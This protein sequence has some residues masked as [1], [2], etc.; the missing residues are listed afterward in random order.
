MD[1][2]LNQTAFVSVIIP[3]FNRA[4]VLQTA[5]DSVLAQR[6]DDYELIVVD[7]GSTDSTPDLL[8]AYGKKITYVRQENRGVSAARNTGIRL[9]RGALITFL[10]SDDHW[11][12]EKLSTQVAFFNTCPDAQIC[13][14]EEIWIRNGIRVNP[15]KKHAKPSGDI[16]QR[17]LSLCLV[18]PSAV[19]LRRELFDDVGLFDETLPACE[20][21][22]LWLRISCRHPVHLIDK[23]LIYKTGGHPDQLSRQAGLDRYRIQSLSRLIKSGH[24]SCTQRDQAVEVLKKKCRIYADGCRKRGRK[25]EADYFEGLTVDY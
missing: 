7:D 22:D 25:D 12:P 23:P 16:F 5:V 13:Q 14:T 1:R 6:F 9:S 21:Y 11:L 10:D 8:A 4:W 17:S 18:S 24:L 20:D 15:R 2:P 19:M 3:T